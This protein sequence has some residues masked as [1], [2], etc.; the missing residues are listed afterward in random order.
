MALS[1]DLVLLEETLALI[2]GQ[3]I[4]VLNQADIFGLAILDGSG[5]ILQVNRPMA[6]FLD[7]EISGSVGRHIYD[8]LIATDAQLLLRFLTGKTPLPKEEFFLNAATDKQSPRSLRC[9]LFIAGDLFFLTGEPALD[10][11]H[12]L[13][14]ELLQLNN[15]LAVI[16]RENIRKGRELS[17]TLEELKRTQ[18]MLIHQEKMASLGQMTAGIAHEI[19]NPVAFVLNNEQVLKRDF[20]DLQAFIATVMDVLPDLAITAPHIHARLVEVATNQ[21]LE[22]LKGTIPR[23]IGANIEGLERIRDIIRDLR[24]FSRLDEAERKPCHVHEGIEAGL[25]FL[26]P[27]LQERGVTVET[28]YAELPPLLCAPGPLNQAITN[29]VVNAIQASHNGQSIRIALFGGADWITIEVTDHGDGIQVEHMDRVFDPFFTTKEVGS[30][31]GL[32]LSIAHQVVASHR[33]R[34][35]LDSSAGSGTVVRIVLP[36]ETGKE[37]SP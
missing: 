2:N 33:G 22:I 10:S 4:S 19:N 16:T 25:R 28:S 8:F 35:T 17:R 1:T 14:E 7:L 15:Q 21:E 13:H 27:L 11:D 6:R 26:K 32:G 5:T 37:L 34:I 23:K 18:A 29:I 20:N 12:K 31:T 24:I 9:R 30:G 3:F 36:V